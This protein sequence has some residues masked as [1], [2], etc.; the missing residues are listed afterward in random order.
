MV[1]FLLSIWLLVAAVLMYR[2]TK[3]FATQGKQ[4]GTRHLIGIAVWPIFFPVGILAALYIA[5]QRKS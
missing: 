2:C 3:G 1:T 5:H 4:I